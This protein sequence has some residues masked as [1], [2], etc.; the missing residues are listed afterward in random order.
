MFRNPLF[1]LVV[2]IGLF[3]AIRHGNRAKKKI[4]EIQKDSGSLKQA[5]LRSHLFYGLEN[6][7]T[8]FDAPSICYFSATDFEKILD[9]AEHLGIGILGIEPWLDGE[10]YDVLVC[11]DFGKDPYDP[12]WYRAA[13]TKFKSNGKALT[14]SATYAVPKEFL[15]K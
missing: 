3:Y 12:S 4:L 6:R 1:F 13:F 7:N 14:F 8:G 5:Y 2:A 11:E 10:F 15:S 9:R